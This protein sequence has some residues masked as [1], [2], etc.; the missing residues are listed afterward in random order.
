MHPRMSCYHEFNE[1]I[2]HRGVLEIL[3]VLSNDG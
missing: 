1:F 3:A 2:D